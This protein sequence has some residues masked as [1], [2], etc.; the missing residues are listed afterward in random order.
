MDIGLFSKQVEWHL[1]RRVLITLNDA[2]ISNDFISKAM[3]AKLTPLQVV[4]YFI[5]EAGLTDVTADPWI[6]P[7]KGYWNEWE[8]NNPYP[9]QSNDTAGHGRVVLR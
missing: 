9:L 3:E 4:Q 7:S 8:R 6:G 1:Q 2:D 5:E